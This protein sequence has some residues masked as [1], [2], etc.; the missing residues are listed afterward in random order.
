MYTN[1]KR[2]EDYFMKFFHN[3]LKLKV[4]LKIK[5]LQLLRLYLKKFK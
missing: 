5:K 2:E 3:V 1:D 4:V